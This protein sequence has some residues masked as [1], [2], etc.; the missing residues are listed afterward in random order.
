MGEEG[1][2]DADY[3]AENA[4]RDRRDRH[5]DIVLSAFEYMLGAIERGSF[6]AMTNGELGMWCQSMANGV[7]PPPAPPPD[8]PS[9]KMDASAEAAMLDALNRSSL[10]FPPEKP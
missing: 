8:A 6:T 4:E 2:T 7:Y 9:I 3:A 5:H 10:F 1:K